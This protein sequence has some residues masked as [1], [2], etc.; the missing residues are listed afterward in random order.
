M[1]VQ[2]RM[3][4]KREAAAELAISGRQL[5]RLIAT[6]QVRVVRLGARAVGVPA[7]E[8]ERFIAVGGVKFP[9]AL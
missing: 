5:D 9:A 7:S 2:K 4:R 1:T 6:K 3:Y 8:I